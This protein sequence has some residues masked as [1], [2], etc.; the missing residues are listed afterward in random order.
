MSISRSNIAASNRHGHASG[1]SQS[2]YELITIESRY[3]QAC[4]SNGLIGIFIAVVD[5]DGEGIDHKNIGRII[6]LV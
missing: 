1:S 2:P 5:N 3:F 4:I 6:D